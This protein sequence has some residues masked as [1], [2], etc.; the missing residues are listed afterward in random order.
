MLCI[1]MMLP[2]TVPVPR[3]E[4]WG[5]GDDTALQLNNI[6]LPDAGRIAML[7]DDVGRIEVQEPF[8]ML[9]YNLLLPSL[10]GH[11]FGRL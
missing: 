2:F 4:T 11:P 5:G 3:C 10:D 1:G 9:I 7:I 8:A 6:A